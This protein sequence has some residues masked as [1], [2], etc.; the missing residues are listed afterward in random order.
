MDF[1]VLSYVA[2]AAADLL[3]PRECMVC[4]RKLLHGERRLCTACLY[5]LPLTYFWL[6]SRNAMADKLNALIQKELEESESLGPDEAMPDGAGA[7]AGDGAE[8]EAP[9][10]AAEACGA[11]DAPDMTEMGAD[12][13]EEDARRTAGTIP[14]ASALALYHYRAGSGYDS[15]SKRLK[16]HGDLA[17]GRMFGKMLARAVIDSP[18]FGIPDVVVP[19]PLHWTREWSRGYNQAGVIAG[20]MARE[21]GIPEAPRLLVRRH[22]TRTQ[23]KLSVVEK[24]ANVKG[25]FAVRDSEAAKL[26]GRES[27]H[28]LMVDDV[29][30]TG[31]TM[32]ECLKALR[33]WFGAAGMG[34]DRLRISVATLGFAG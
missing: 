33:A 28:I 34:P 31:A 17:A 2:G 19:V 9:Q 20:A 16:Y 21:L 29:F 4:G 15:I 13:A 10:R 7:A 3:M 6:Q 32:H 23:T 18:Y 11:D 25:A 8:D 24:A 26:A 22:R 30:T 27:L 5:D 14:Y 1:G 12:G